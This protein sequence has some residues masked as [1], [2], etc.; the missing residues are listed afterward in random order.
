MSDKPGSSS[1]AHRKTLDPLRL[2]RVLHDCLELDYF[3]SVNPKT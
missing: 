2:E 3:Y 1:A